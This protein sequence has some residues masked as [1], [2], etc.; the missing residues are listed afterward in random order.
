[1]SFQTLS[2]PQPAAAEP[3][4]RTGTAA[5]VAVWRSG[6]LA[7]AII[8]AAAGALRLIDLGSVRLD[9][10]YDA[11]VKSMT[12][13]LHNFF[14]G[15]FE[16]GGSVSIDKPPLDLWLQVASVKLFGFT[17]TALKLPEALAGTLSVPLLFGGLRPVF[18]VRAALAAALAMAVLPIEVITARSDTMDAVMMMLV[19]L[20]LLCAVRACQT[21]S[22]LWLVGAGVAF[23]LAFNVK[24][25]E[26]MIA[27]PGLAVL[28][29]FGLPGARRKRLLQLLMVTAVYVVVALSW[30]TA[31]L[32][33]PAH[34]RPFAIGS[35]NGSAWNAAFVFNGTSRLTG[36]T[37]EG[38]QSSFESN[39][40]YPQATQAERDQIPITP[41]SATRLLDRIGPLSGQRLGLEILAA[42][43]LGLP[44]LAFGLRDQ[45]LAGLAQAKPERRMQLA[46]AL[47]LVVW[48]FTGIA[49]FSVMTRLHPR[50]VEAFT[51]VV[52]AL[53]GIGAAWATGAKGRARLFTLLVCLVVLTIYSEH[54]LFSPSGIW[55]IVL[56]SALGAITLATLVRVIKSSSALSYAL[57][58]T[59]AFA[60]TMTAVLA[61]P[62]RSSIEAIQ[63]KTSDAGNV[64]A[65]R[66]GEQ[67]LISA[68][69]LAHQGNARYEVAA[70]S[71]TKVSSLIVADARPVVVLTTY[72]ARTLTTVAKLKQL[73]ARGELR[74]AFLDSLCG[75]HTPSTNAACSPPALWIRAH[76]TDVSRQAGL[77]R[78]KVL[79][80]LPGALA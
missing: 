2:T 61:I 45:S 25:L 15:A 75:S 8:T 67:K 58:G 22:T 19:V 74:Y 18:G 3:A 80:R 31:T 70:D 5:F 33:F 16:P 46:V 17:S 34:D 68:Y 1:M 77:S 65:L 29:Y 55:L 4:R 52:A 48:M 44:A 27:L 64:G 9:P 32:F 51:P 56:A 30:L 26:S 76:A 54:L 10:F 60:M 40:R 69:L 35:T 47:G 78:G 42:L 50:Y 53:L 38:S 49:L 11:A 23:G 63:T 71:A 14:F 43:L 28:V 66:N 41:P 6:W 73:I 24:L 36:K 72:N 59:V 12:L 13:S 7:A 57:A 37:V 39:F 79:W 20:C 21:G 62:L